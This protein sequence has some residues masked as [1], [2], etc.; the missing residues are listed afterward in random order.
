MVHDKP[1]IGFLLASIHT[2]SALN[3]WT[4]LIR[5]ASHSDSAF[6]IFPGGRLNVVKDSEYL[7]NSIYRLANSQNLDGLI[8]WGSS[9]GGAV[10]VEELNSFH[11]A[12]S[13]MPYVTIA[14]KM[15]GHPC[16]TF[17][18]YNGMADLVRHFITCHKAT[19]IAFLRGPEEHVSAEERYQA[20]CDVMASAGYD[21]RTSALVSDP[22]PWGDGDVAM[23]Q[24][25]HDRGLIPGRDFEVLIGS[26]DMMT[27]SAVRYLQKYGY[28]VPVDYKCAGFNDSVE[29]RILG[30]STVHMPYSELVLTT[31]SM[32]R[33]ALTGH[34]KKENDVLLAT[35]LVIRESCGC[36]GS[37]C[38]AS[39]SGTIPCDKESL[40]KALAELFR[41]DETYTNA[42]IEPLIGAIEYRDTELFF[43]LLERVLE[44]FFLQDMDIRLLYNAFAIVKNASVFSD[45]WFAGLETRFYMTISRIQNSVRESSRFHERHLH[46]RL[47]SLK[48]DLLAVRSRKS[49]LDILSNH[50]PLLGVS[51]GALVLTENDTES[52]FI[53][54]FTPETR[55]NEEKLFSASLLLPKNITGFD[56]GVFLVQPLFM[57]KQPMGYFICSVPLYEGFVFEELRSSISSALTGIF[58]FEENAAAK[59][60]AEQAELAKTSFFANVGKDLSEPLVE[61]SRKIDQVQHLLESGCTDND[62]LS[63]QMV[64]LKNRISEQLDKTELVID[65]TRSQTNEL[66]F[67]KHL[68]HVESV[69]GSQSGAPALP[70]LYGDPGR[71]R[72]ALRILC[73]EWNVPFSFLN[74]EK[75]EKG[76]RLVIEG[77]NTVPENVWQQNNLMLAENILFLAG[78]SIEKTPKGCTI[79]YPWPLFSCRNAVPGAALFEW[80]ADTAQPEDWTH[81]YASRTDPSFSEAAFLC[82]TATGDRDLKKVQTFSGLFELHMS[83]CVKS[84]VLFIGVPF[85][86]YP[87]WV[88]EGKVM[89]IASMAEFSGVVNKTVPSLV[90]FDTLDCE[91]V[92]Q[93]RR[94][95]V[96][97]LCPVFVLPEEIDDEIK[98]HR[99]MK[100]PRI[101]LCNS[102]IAQGEEFAGRVRSILAGDEILPPDTGALVKKAVYYFN[103]NSGT[104]ISRW[105]LADSV[106]VSEDYLT[107]IFH[108]EIGLSPW[109]YLNRYRIFQ[110]SKMLLHTNFTI[111]EISEK[112]G[113]QDQAYFCR[114]FKKIYGIPPGRYRSKAEN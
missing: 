96:T 7:R 76:L 59:Q 42:A 63:A 18:A 13:Q 8:S 97:V 27:F 89:Q 80:N 22:F 17:D 71:L 46:A 104:Q 75:T 101:I 43:S 25:Y 14:H 24:L 52:C 85:S 65:L 87:Q 58:L 11:N 70:L 60:K 78:A 92:E 29:S 102:S 66:L 37:S 112:C 74:P 1:R 93:V 64:F 49:L 38:F 77:S 3:M 79:L 86:K 99:L 106:H 30:F 5:E 6:Y 28:K 15:P 54:S 50:L 47:N 94:H 39:V 114:V 84:P 48:C 4:M 45:E 2:G 32:I 111:Y 95:P 82:I 33:N 44:R 88:T 81:L 10:P 108:R 98:V 91:A 19:K 34:K 90:V 105:K 56:T 109:E 57:E 67:E 12:F 31:F 51:R 61:V 103:C 26:S 73:D 68:F 20:F 83:S 9:I 100:I 110:A 72:Q 69:I 23:R 55:C 40:T 53:G 62:I 41:L 107:R 36:T 16:V 21:M 113:F 35:D